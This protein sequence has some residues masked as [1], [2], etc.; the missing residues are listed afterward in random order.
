MAKTKILLAGGTGLIGQHI[1]SMLPEDQ[2]EIHLLSRSQREDHG[3]IKYFQWDVINQTIDLK[4]LEVD[5]II[6]LTGAGIAD[7]RWTASRKKTIIDSRVDSI[8]LLI[9]GLKEINHQVKSVASASAIGYYGDRS[10]EILIESSEPGSGFLG[11]CCLLWENAAKEFET[12]SQRT[13]ILRVGIVLS[14]KGG[15]LPKV[16]MTAPLRLLNYFGNGNQYYSWIHITDICRCFIKSILDD[17]YSGVFNAVTPLPLTNKDFT[18]KVGEGMGGGYAVLP[19]PAFGLRIALG[20]M[21]DVVL[22]SNRVLPQQLQDAGFKWNF[23][24]LPEAIRHL[25]KAKI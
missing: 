19:A 4:A 11:E 21:A 8:R 7:Q 15:A 20:Q 10:D 1:V 16:L 5:H 6:N 25:R 9:K 17:S 13:A 22:N 14:N 3:N 23:P 18:K 12:V 24:D 2:Y